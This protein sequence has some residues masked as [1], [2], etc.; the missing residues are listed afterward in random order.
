VSTATHQPGEGRTIWRIAATLLSLACFVGASNPA[1]AQQ[2]PVRTVRMIVPYTPGGGTDV[3]ARVIAAEL[4]K[5]L[6]QSVVVENKPGAGGVLGT[7]SVAKARPDGYTVGLISSGHA[8]NPA[9]YASMPFDSIHDIA[10]VIQV[11]SGPNV[12]VVNADVKAGSLSGL[13]ELARAEPGRLTY[14]SAGVGNPTHLAGE[15]LQ[16][17]AEI[18][19]VHVPYKGS[20][21]AEIALAGGEITMMIDSI[22][23]ALPFITSGKTR[24]LAVTGDERFPLLPNVPTIA[25]AGL[26]GFDMSTWWGVV[27]PAGTP[28]DVIRRLNTSIA[29]ILRRPDIRKQF[30]QFGAQPITGSP[31]QFGEYIRSETERYSRLIKALGIQ[32]IS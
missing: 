1:H 9:L 22:P 26:R 10:P 2:Y 14:G 23:A 32:P 28:D 25:E 17:A 6:Q 3:M 7:D 8:I 24:A 15:L 13:I 18:K 16:R 20:G 29:D 30:L 5:M 27:A 31:S 11:A 21:Q 12:I 19:L 4:T